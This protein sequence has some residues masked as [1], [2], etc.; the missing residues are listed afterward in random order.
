MKDEVGTRVNYALQL[1]IDSGRQVCINHHN[2]KPGER[3]SKSELK[4][5][6]DIYGSRWLTSGC[7]SV[8]GLSGEPG[9]PLVTL[10]HLKQP[11][12]DIGLLTLQHDHV[13]GTT[14]LHAGTDLLTVIRQRGDITAT[15]AAKVLCD[16]RAVTSTNR[17]R[18]ASSHQGSSR[19]R[20]SNTERTRTGQ[21]GRRSSEPNRRRTGSERNNPEHRASRDHMSE[22]RNLLE[23][24]KGEREAKPL[25]VDQALQFAAL[26]V[27]LATAEFLIRLVGTSRG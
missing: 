22:A 1:V 20:T 3:G 14:T 15:D 8:L 24:A 21:P 16:V 25:T 9:D 11:A 4:A 17:T 18:E 10:R 7:G 26:E 12:E 5:L 23:Y 6:A 27:S 13:T 2:R 19:T